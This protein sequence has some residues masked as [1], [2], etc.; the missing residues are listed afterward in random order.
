MAEVPYHQS[1]Q[2]VN[3]IVNYFSSRLRAASIG[4]L[5]PENE[6]KSWRLRWLVW[7]LVIFF[8]IAIIFGSLIFLRF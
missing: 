4:L 5:A 2:K 7:E 1:S 3:E 8:P 6:D